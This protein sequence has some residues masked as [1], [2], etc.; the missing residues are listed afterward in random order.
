MM[1]KE[2]W[3]KAVVYQIYPK[4]FR[5]ADGDGSGDIKGITERLDYL[6]WLGAD[7]LWVCPVYL[8]L[9]HIFVSNHVEMD[10]SGAIPQVME[11]MPNA[12][13]VTSAPSGLKGLKAHYGDKYQYMGVKAG[14]SLKLGSRSLNFVATPMPVS[15][16]HL[17]VYKRQDYDH[18]AAV[19]N[20]NI[21]YLAHKM[22]E[23]YKGYGSVYHRRYFIN[24][25][26]RLYG[27]QAFEVKMPS[28]G[29]AAMRY[30]AEEGRYC[31]SLLYASP[32]TRGAVEVIEDMPPLYNVPVKIHVCLLYTSCLLISR[33]L[34]G[35]GYWKIHL[36]RK[37]RRQQGNCALVRLTRGL[38]TAS[39][40]ESPIR[41]I[42]LMHPGHR[43]LI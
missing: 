11:A 18:A 3:K 41:Q 16:T 32:I 25:L 38:Y 17:D 43:R 31:L 24:A 30:Q 5:D 8:S 42:I 1:E 33:R 10:H 22:G 14:D 37:R 12:V 23:I 28:A 39:Q 35:H 4:S 6:K 9:I 20:G 27:A 26:R 29:R 13:I 40:A 15:Y 36:E 2:W 21:M 7:V 34:N 19:Q